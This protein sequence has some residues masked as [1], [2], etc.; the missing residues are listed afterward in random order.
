MDVF[1]LFYVQKVQKLV[2]F[3][4]HFTFINIRTYYDYQWVIL[5]YWFLNKYSYFVA[6]YPQSMLFLIHDT[7]IFSLFPPI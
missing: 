6:L 7:I 2:T 3:L 1:F 4:S 5:F